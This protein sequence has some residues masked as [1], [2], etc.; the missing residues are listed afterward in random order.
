MLR[1]AQSIVGN[2]IRQPALCAF[3][4]SYVQAPDRGNQIEGRILVQPGHR[5]L[6]DLAMA[7]SP[8]NINPD[9][10]GCRYAWGHYGTAGRA[11]DA[12][13]AIL[14]LLFSRQVADALDT[15]FSQQVI[16]CMAKKDR[17]TSDEV[18]QWVM[19]NL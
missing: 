1:K 17:L 3:D 19:E 2:P 8:E 10:R 5:D 12:A 7:M 14:A 4:F 13:H 18:Y 15:A 9:R 6:F 11:R 16:N